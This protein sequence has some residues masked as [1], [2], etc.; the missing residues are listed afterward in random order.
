MEMAS[1]GNRHCANC[2][3]TLLFPVVVVA[4]TSQ[5]QWRYSNNNSGDGSGGLQCKQRTPKVRE[6]QRDRTRDE[7]ASNNRKRSKHFD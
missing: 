1:P 6:L 3:G 2:I 5:Q 7:A 4:I